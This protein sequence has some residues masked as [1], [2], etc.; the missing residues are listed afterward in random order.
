[1]SVR[2]ATKYTGGSEHYQK[3]K[4]Q[5]WDAMEVSFT[6]E[7]FV[8]FLKGC[9]VKRLMRANTKGAQ[10]EDLIKAHHEIGKAIEVLQ[11]EDLDVQSS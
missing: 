6:K 2:S 7:E 11:I 4:I 3:L 5:P 10:L 1:M 9:A 8:G